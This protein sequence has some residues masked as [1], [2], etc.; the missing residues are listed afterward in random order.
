MKKFNDLVSV[1]IPTYKRYKFLKKCILQVIHQDYKNLEI[2]ISD[3]SVR[4]LPKDIKKIILNDKRIKYFQ[5]SKNLGEI[6]NDFFIRSKFNGVYA[7][8]IHTDDIIPLNY[9]S[10]LLDKIKKLKNCSLVGSISHRYYEDKFWYKYDNFKLL[11]DNRF[12]RVNYVLERV[13]C[14]PG[15]LEYLMHGLYKLSDYPTRFKFGPRG[16]IIFFILSMS[17]RGKITTVGDIE[18]L[19]KNTNRKNIEKY[20]S[21]ENFFTKHLPFF[22]KFLIRVIKILKIIAIVYKSKNFK[23]F[24]K[25]T[26]SISSIKFL[27]IK[28]KKQYFIPSE[29]NTTS[30]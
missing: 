5:Q 28:C 22:E 26:L 30:Q 12:V 24:E 17:I 16:T 21:F 15:M 19:I 9:I 8:I 10:K 14:S 3:N 25:L 2:I 18:P 20:S 23:N 1:G 27:F 11:N 29:P 4:S 6:G 13:F 7:C